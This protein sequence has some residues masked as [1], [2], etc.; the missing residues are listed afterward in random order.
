MSLSVANT[1]RHTLPKAARLRGEKQI[2]RLFRHPQRKSLT[3]YPLRMIYT[4]ELQDN[5]TI[6]LR[7]MLSVPKR[8]LRHAV[9][10]NRAKRQLRE[11]IRLHMP[12]LQQTIRQRCP[13]QHIHAAL[14][15]L[16]DTPLTTLQVRQCVKSILQ[17]LNDR[18]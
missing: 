11:A 5:T 1:P 16:S 15:W 8:L 4:I 6:P 18:L 12:Q 7:I 3:A 9:D 2:E 14:L 13:Q 17:R 10:R